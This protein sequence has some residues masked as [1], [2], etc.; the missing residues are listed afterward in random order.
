MRLLG[1]TLRA[2]NFLRREKVDIVVGTGGRTTL[3]VGLAAKS[4]G[5]PMVLMEQNAVPGRANRLLAPLARRV[6]LGLPTAHPTRRSL[7]TG[8]PLRSEF[9]RINRSEARRGLGLTVDVPVVFVTGGSQG[10][11]TLNSLVPDALCR[12][13]R[14]LQVLHLSGPGRGENMRLRYAAGEAHGITAMV[15]SHAF[16]MPNYYAAA[17]LVICRGGGGTVAELASAGRPSIIIPYPHHRDRQQYFNGKILEEVGAAV[18][19]NEHGLSPESLAALVESLFRRGGLEAMGERA[20]EVAMTD[21]CDDIVE[22]LDRLVD[23][24]RRGS[25]RARREGAN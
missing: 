21:A 9:G 20:Q 6:Y 15:R 10:A 24:A 18:V 12:L 23:R 13:R 16:D 17:D 2:R 11:R 7:L 22:D 14:P 8:T 3:P 25:G 5:L 4:L 1:A 19:L